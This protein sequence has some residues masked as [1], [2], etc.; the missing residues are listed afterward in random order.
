M[1]FPINLIFL[2]LPLHS[3]PSMVYFECRKFEHSSKEDTMN[4]MIQTLTQSAEALKTAKANLHSATVSLTN[5]E[6]ILTIAKAK[7]ISKG[8][9]VGKNEA[10]RNASLALLLTEEVKSVEVAS[11]SVAEAK[12]NHDIAFVDFQVARYAI[13][14]TTE[15]I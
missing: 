3:F 8:E 4:E 5:A 7:A 10:E 11:D 6:R 13:R 14:A 9:I 12:T 15:D 1:S 2:D